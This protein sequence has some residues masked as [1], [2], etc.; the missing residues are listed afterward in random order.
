ML[1]FFRRR[2]PEG[3]PPAEEAYSHSVQQL[4]PRLRPFIGTPRIF[5]PG[6]ADGAPEIF[7]GLVA[8]V[9]VDQ[10]SRIDFVPQDSMGALF[11]D[12]VDIDDSVARQRLMTLAVDNFRHL[13]PPKLTRVPVLDGRT[14]S[15][16]F[17]AQT[18]HLF[19]AAQ[20]LN[21]NDLIA[22]TKNVSSWPHGLLVA[23]PTWRMVMFHVVSGTAVLKVLPHMCNAALGLM[24]EAR[25]QFRILPHV[26]FV[27]PDGRVQQVTM[28]REGEI[29]VALAGPISEVLFGQN[30]LLPES[31]RVELENI[32]IN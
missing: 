2:K 23:V 30:G 22:A 9:A 4:A 8:T 12:G 18:D 14:D 3:G 26:Y 7:P 16:V 17:I 24:N 10:G 27:A 19:G 1:G 6:I 32:R 15:D 31:L 21:L 25:E 20:I 5:P 29:M 13:S 28:L 11:S